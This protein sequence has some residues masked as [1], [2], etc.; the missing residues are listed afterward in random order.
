MKYGILFSF[1]ILFFPGD[2]VTAQE[3]PANQVYGHVKLFFNDMLMIGDHKI[4]W[5]K[6]KWHESKR[7][8]YLLDNTNQIRD[9]MKCNAIED[10]VTLD[11]STFLIWDI[12]YEVKIRIRDDQMV[13]KRIVWV[14]SSFENHYGLSMILDQYMIGKK[15][16]PKQ[17]CAIFN[18]ADIARTSMPVIM[19]KP[20]IN[21]KGLYN[22]SSKDTIVIFTLKC[23]R[24]MLTSREEEK[25]FEENLKNVDIKPF[26]ILDQRYTCHNRTRDYYGW[27]NVEIYGNDMFIYEKNS[28]AVFV[29]DMDH[30]LQMT[31][32]FVL[33]VDD[34]TTEGWKYF[35]D[36][37]SGK[38]FAVKRAAMPVTASRSKK[39][40]VHYEYY[41]YNLDWKNKELSLI[42]KTE[43]KPV[44]I[45][46]ENI[47]VLKPS[48]NSIDIIA[49]S[50]TE[51]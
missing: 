31:D 4:L 11:D 24:N 35:F 28:C 2:P 5:A 48:K 30:H 25:I 46:K 45:S 32:L 37:N 7:K 41:V 8:M 29:F 50:L 39:K 22:L 20:D 34:R 17:D 44:Y 19:K 15:Y 16:L 40:E 13:M 36:R 9:T 6:D 26:T 10:I 38:H 14:M 23:P 33:P 21:E 42:Q 47:Y 27:D 12:N 49:L 18:A 43:L 51:K 1:M 3:I